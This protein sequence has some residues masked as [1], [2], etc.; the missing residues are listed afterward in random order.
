LS[1]SSCSAQERTTPRSVTLLSLVSTT[2]L[3]E[4]ISA[5]RLNAAS[6]FCFTSPAWA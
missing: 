5:L 3:C 6:M 2:M 4:S 1:A